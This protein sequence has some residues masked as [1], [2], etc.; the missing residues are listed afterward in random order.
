M[1]ITIIDVACRH[2]QTSGS[3]LVVNYLARYVSH[4]S[5]GR[6]AL[7]DVSSR[8]FWVGSVFWGWVLGQGFS[9]LVRF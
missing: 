9:G 5:S 7:F 3:N 6:L 2:V 8:G 4:P 1:S